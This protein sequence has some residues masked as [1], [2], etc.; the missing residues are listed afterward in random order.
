[1]KAPKTFIL[2][3]SAPW[4]ISYEARVVKHLSAEQIAA[5]TS[6]T[7]LSIGLALIPI[8]VV[9]FKIKREEGFSKIITDDDIHKSLSHNIPPEIAFSNTDYELQRAKTM[10]DLYLKSIPL[11]IQDKKTAEEKEKVS[12]EKITYP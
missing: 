2:K 3:K 9:L 7:V 10:I 11:F 5:L 12:Y 4:G 1:M 6:F 8:V